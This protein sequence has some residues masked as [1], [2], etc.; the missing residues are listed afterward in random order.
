MDRDLGIAIGQ[1]GDLV[2]PP[3]EEIDGVIRETRNCLPREAP[4]AEQCDA[5]A[6]GESTLRDLAI[7]A[8]S[9]PGQVLCADPFRI[10]DE[11]LHPGSG[12]SSGRSV[13]RAEREILELPQ[14]LVLSDQRRMQPA[15]HFE[16]ESV[17]VDP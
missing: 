17:S 9:D 15:D 3:A 2:R 12:A 5:G 16:E 6:V 10:G 4:R 1:I 8:T 13:G 7:G 11:T 14:H